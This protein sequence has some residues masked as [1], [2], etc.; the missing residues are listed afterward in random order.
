M[1]FF[2]S[3]F[4]FLCLKRLKTFLL[5]YFY[6]L[7]FDLDPVKDQSQHGFTNKSQLLSKH[8]QKKKEFIKSSNQKLNFLYLF[9]FLTMLYCNAETNL[10]YVYAYLSAS[11]SSKTIKFS[12]YTTD[13]QFLFGHR[14]FHRFFWT[15]SDTMMEFGL[16]MTGVIYFLLFS[17]SPLQN[18]F[19]MYLFVD[20]QNENVKIVQSGK[21][22]FV[23][24]ENN[25]VLNHH[26]S[27]V[28]DKAETESIVLYRK[29][30]T[31][32]NQIVIS[33]LY[34]SLVAFFLANMFSNWRGT[35]YDYLTW[36]ITLL[37]SI[38]LPISN[39]S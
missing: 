39:Y 15:Q 6:T 24:F 17:A 26:F 21:G 22:I 9:P 34:S 29:R 31:K 35:L 5:T 13:T 7:L 12:N 23:R 27:I 32:F 16:L 25:K 2:K 1:N 14:V 8:S 11:L 30:A 33:I 28:L 18:K 10:F 4:T 19:V 37:A 3:I 20:R 38:Y 36:P